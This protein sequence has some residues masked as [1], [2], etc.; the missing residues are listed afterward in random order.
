MTTK[1][2]NYFSYFKS[3]AHIRE[4]SYFNKSEQEQMLEIL[5]KLRE[6]DKKPRVDKAV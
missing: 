5:K 4:D 2:E 6:E 3:K 1:K